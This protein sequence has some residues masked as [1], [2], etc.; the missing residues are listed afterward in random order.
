VTNSPILREKNGEAGQASL[1][2]HADTAIMNDA[3]TPTLSEESAL[4]DMSINL[5]EGRGPAIRDRWADRLFRW[6]SGLCAAA[7]MALLVVLVLF[8]VHGSLLAFRDHGLGFILSPQWDPTNQR[9]GAL[10]FIFGTVYTS[11]IGLAIALPLGVMT[12]VAL[13]EILPKALSKV[14]G[15][16]VE[17]LAAIPSV[18]LG[19]WGIFV[20]VPLIRKVEVAIYKSPLHLRDF[21]LFSGAPIGIGYLSAGVLLAIMVLPLIVSVCREVITQVP[22]AQREAA[23]ALGATKWEVI[24]M[25]VLPYGWRGVFGAGMLGLARALGE[26]MAVTMVIGN[27][28]QI[29]AS[30]FATGYTLASVIANEF[31]EA[32][33]DLAIS[34]LISLGLILFVLTLLINSAAR[35][36]LTFLKRRYGSGVHAH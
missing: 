35:L 14:I 8:M 23:F 16:A 17:L 30:L 10:T 12:S 4:A 32:P 24:R 13:V 3:M 36:F 26:T 9:Y 31:T 22:R 29:K 21:P 6:A 20:I 25:A 28:P 2:V 34:S 11:I 1:S 33:S 15:L 5:P 19:L 7:I 27:T 18:L